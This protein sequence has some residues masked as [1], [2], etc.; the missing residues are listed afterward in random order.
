MTIAYPYIVLDERFDEYRCGEPYGG[1]SVDCSECNKMLGGSDDKSI[2]TSAMSG[3]KVIYE[4][5][6]P[7]KHFYLSLKARIG[8][9]SAQVLD[10][11]ALNIHLVMEGRH[12]VA[13]VRWVWSE[14]Q[15]NG[16]IYIEFIDP[17][18][19][20]VIY[21]YRYGKSLSDVSFG[22]CENVSDFYYL[23]IVIYRSDEDG[24]I[25][26]VIGDE[27]SGTCIVDTNTGIDG[28]PLVSIVLEPSYK[29]LYAGINIYVD[30]I[31]LESDVPVHAYVE[32]YREQLG[33]LIES[34]ISVVIAVTIL[35]LIMRMVMG[36]V[37]WVRSIG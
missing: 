5:S 3:R 23:D 31:Y 28:A 17:N 20:N 13:R 9:V 7:L 8:Y 10:W 30:D 18:T 25:W 24:K 1:W 36:V 27:K 35:M 32:M 12:V 11:V 19:G 22:R 15:P 16:A 34:I 2:Y 6:A 14:N 26:F 21:S 29:A 4:F 37:T 33:F